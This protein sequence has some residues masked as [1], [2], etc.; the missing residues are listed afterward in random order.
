MS[1]VMAGITFYYHLHEQSD[2]PDSDDATT[3]A[4][5]TFAPQRLPSLY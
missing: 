3:A 4:M 5:N 1:I 2:Q